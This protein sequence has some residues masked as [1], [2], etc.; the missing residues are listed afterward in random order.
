M[1]PIIVTVFI[2]STSILRDIM[3]FIKL[4]FSI[5]VLLVIYLAQDNFVNSPKDKLSKR[6]HQEILR[7]SNV[8]I[9]LLFYL[10]P[11]I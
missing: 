6:K 9:E 1:L 8:C 2:A 7:Q 5:I 10:N 3:D 11:S 4:N